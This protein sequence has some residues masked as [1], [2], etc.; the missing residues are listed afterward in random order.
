MA[1]EVIILRSETPGFY[2]INL[3]ARETYPRIPRLV[4]HL[5]FPGIVAFF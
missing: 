4:G 3:G 2:I 5:S 1:N